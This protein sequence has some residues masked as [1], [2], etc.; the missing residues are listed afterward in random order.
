MKKKALKITGITLLIF[1]VLIAAVPFLL[2]GKIADIIKNKV[3][4]S[5]NATLDFDEANLSLIKSFPNA[6]VG[7]KKI[8]LVNKAPFEGDTLFASEE[9]ELKMSIKE[10]FKSAEDPIAI[11]SLN[12]DGAKLHI[13]VDEGENTNYDIAIEGE[14]NP[15][16]GPE[17][18]SNNF[19]LALDS[20][21][22]NN[23]EIIY[24]DFAAGIHL[25]ISEMN[26]SGTG[27]LSLEN[28]QLKTLTDALVSFEMDS[29]KYL[30]NN[31]LSLDALIDI[32]L[33]ENKYSFLENKA[34]VNQLP[35]VFDGFIKVN[36]ENQEVDITFKTPSSD[37]KNFLAVIPEA[38]SKNI[39]DVKTTGNFEV[40]GQF[41]GIVDETHIPTFSIKM[42]SENASFKYPD[43]P[44]TVRNVFI[45]T[46]INNTTGITEDTYVEIKKLSFTIDEDRFNLNS[47]ITDLLGNTKV[48]AHMD[49]RINLA[50]ISQ[51]Y[52]VPADYN[53]KGIMNADVTTAFDM[54][55]LEKKQ[56]Q[57]T[58]TSGSVDIS[59]FEYASE[60]LKNPVMVSKADITFN[61]QTVSLNSFNGKTGSTD[62]NTT[63]TLTNL[64]GFMFND[65]KVEGN[66]ALTSN[67]FA[68]NDFMVEEEEG[69]AQTEETTTDEKTTSSK[70]E[71][72]I[73]IP[74]FLDCTID[75]KA[76]TVLYDNLNLKNVEGTLVI[77][78]ETAT[79]K[80]FRSNLFGG[81]LGVA[82]S[83]STKEEVSTFDLDLGMENFGISESFQSLELFK[84][85]AP[86][87]SALQGKLNSDVKIAG[88]LKEDFTPNLATISGGLL[89]ELLSTKVDTKNAPLLSA[90]DSKLS[91][92]NTEELDFNDLKTAL[93]FKNGAVNVEPFTLN[94]KDIAVNVDGGH[95]FDKEL[96]YKAT[97]Q[98]PAKYL[99]SEVTG[100]IAKLDDDS[101]EDLTIPVVANIGGNYTSPTVSTDLSSGVAK[102]TNQLVEIQKQKLL[103]QGKS[104][105]KD[106]LGDVFKTDDSDSTKTGNSGGV[107]EALGSLLGSTK[108]DTAKIDS[109]QAKKEPVKEAAKSILGGLLSKKKKKKDSVE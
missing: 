62:F 31:K 102:L 10:L 101:L 57:N 33:K 83:V 29:T 58:K 24:D 67:T 21:A 36:E 100:L 87:A 16:A 19:T 73:K 82:G 18:T 53:L 105:A 107:K 17:E 48:N 92:L 30:N 72:R 81:V 6:N 54:A 25:V 99:G 34:L 61:P 85:L 27:D 75:A 68:L 2:E 9:I 79:L 26:H 4:N 5:I 12:I 69:E 51:A 66:F 11:Q 97:L 96:Q 109:A 7:L 91:F 89:A 59:D 84:V 108:K 1:I 3:N 76:N 22:I 52:P 93:S 64:L 23:T 49:G 55:S 15:T 32:D 95:T 45:D 88:N 74:S 104:A 8:S 65:E 14:A 103:N 60:E 42:N 41:K 56:Y 37:F 71:E 98:V 47:K 90:L 43:L 28:S 86:L 70:T 39:E 77:R 46:E 44:K 38:Y 35:L 63:G 106:L 78:D 50:N 13:K 94:Y 20:Y 80:N 40:N